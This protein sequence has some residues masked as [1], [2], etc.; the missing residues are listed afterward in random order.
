LSKKDKP[1]FWEILPIV[2]QIVVLILTTVLGRKKSCPKV[3]PDRYS[4][5]CTPALF[6]AG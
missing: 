2:A 6:L 1:D 3:L 5:G 4:S